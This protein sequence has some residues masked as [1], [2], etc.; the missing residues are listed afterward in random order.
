MGTPC[1][2]LCVL[3]TLSVLGVVPTEDR[4][5]YK[6]GDKTL[7]IMEGRNASLFLTFNLFIFKGAGQ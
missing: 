2:T 4:G 1:K 7:Y 6:T 3:M 5:N